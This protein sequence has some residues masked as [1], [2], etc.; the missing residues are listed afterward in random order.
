[1][2]LLEFLETSISA[3]RPR[4]Y[5]RSSVGQRINSFENIKNIYARSSGKEE[6][7]SANTR[8][9]SRYFLGS[10]INP[11]ILVRV[12]HQYDVIQCDGA[13]PAPPRQAPDLYGMRFDVAGAG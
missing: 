2:S 4:K 11:A 1:M 8:C 6:F 7:I 9:H 12:V 3:K 13:A 10:T 5:Q